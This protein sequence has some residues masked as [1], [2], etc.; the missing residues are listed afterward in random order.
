MNN[1]KQIKKELKEAGFDVKK[2][3]VR[4]DGSYNIRIKDLSINLDKVEAIARKYENYSRCEYS[5]EILSGGNT[6]VF[7]QLDWK[8]ES[9][10]KQS[11]EFL[12]FAKN[13][14]NKLKTSKDVRVTENLLIRK[15]DGGFHIYDSNV[16][17]Y[18]NNYYNS[19]LNAT[20]FRVFLEVKQNG[21]NILL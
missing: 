17:N 20:A 21:L 5:G 11:V 9:E 2:I 16:S 13:I 7:V 8:A 3:S 6:F 10:A 18:F 12:D 1:S 19:N 15:Y 4:Y 14:E